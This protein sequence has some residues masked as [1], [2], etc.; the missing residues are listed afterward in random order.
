MT[1]EA[2]GHLLGM[3]FV[4]VIAMIGIYL[5]VIGLGQFGRRTGDAPGWVLLAAGTGFLLAAGSFGLSAAG[6]ILYG[7]KAEPD[8]S[9]SDDAPYAIRTAQIVLSLGIIA[10]LATV[11]TW[12]AFNP[13]DNS[14]TGRKIAFAAGAFTTWLIFA[15]F[16]IWKIRR[17]RR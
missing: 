5:V 2:K 10:M 15:G 12:V 8:G 13:G 1:P 4:A 6:G 16:T 7:A 17:L 9:L 14:S 11:A 3:L